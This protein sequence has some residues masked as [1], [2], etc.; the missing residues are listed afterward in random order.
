MYE[1]TPE[2]TVPILVIP[3]MLIMPIGVEWCGLMFYI[4]VLIRSL[5]TSRDPEW[6]ILGKFS[7]DG[8]VGTSEYFK[9]VM[10]PLMAS[11]YHNDSSMLYI[12]LG[13]T[14]LNTFSYLLFT[15]AERFNK[16]DKVV[17]FLHAVSAFMGIIIAFIDDTPDDYT[18]DIEKYLRKFFYSSYWHAVTASILIFTTLIRVF[19]YEHYNKIH[20]S[21]RYLTYAILTFSLSLLFISLFYSENFFKYSNNYVA[22]LEVLVLFHIGY[23]EGSLFKIHRILNKNVKIF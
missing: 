7:E 3:F 18:D 15:D 12:R 10:S 21:C 19:F 16:K 1:F 9:P 11:Y 13:F 17:K 23:V 5:L 2:Q 20:A 8:V 4:S 6:N 22:I 14:M